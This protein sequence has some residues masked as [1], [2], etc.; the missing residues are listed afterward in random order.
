MKEADE[1]REQNNIPDAYFIALGRVTVEWSYLE[2]V[3]DLGLMKL[4]GMSISDSRA[5]SVFAHM[6]FPLKIDVFGALVTEL[7]PKYPGLKELKTILQQIKE[8]QSARNEVIHAK[9]GCENGQVM[10]SRLSA[11]G[12]IKTSVRAI[13]LDELNGVGGKIKET[14]KALYRFIVTGHRDPT[15]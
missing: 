3:F 10:I 5:W 14:T 12:Q 6:T 8:A 1:D 2:S 9:W 11:R 15:Y 7:Q 4:A 13:S